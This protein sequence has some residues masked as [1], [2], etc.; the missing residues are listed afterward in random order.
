MREASSN[1]EAQFSYL[2]KDTETIL[3]LA[4]VMRVG[5]G[6]VLRKVD[7]FCRRSSMTFISLT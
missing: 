6:S 5:F 2:T 3:Y 4:I 7:I 1:T